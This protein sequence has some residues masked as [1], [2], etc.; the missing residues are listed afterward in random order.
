MRKRIVS[1]ILLAHDG[2][3][4][5]RAAED[6]L[7]GWPIFDRPPLEVLSVA[8]YHSAMPDPIAPGAQEGSLEA[9]RQAL[10]DTRQR[11]EEIA[12]SA[13][14][15]LERL[16]WQ[17]TWD[18]RGGDPTHVI[19]EEA[20]AR[21]IDLVVMGTHGRTGLNRMVLG[22]VAH[23]VLTHAHCSVLVVRGKVPGHALPSTERRTTVAV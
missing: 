21:G 10:G 8:R 15:R 6:V 2:S 4:Q 9:Y 22:S 20:E 12:H 19:V 13:S 1:R 11:Y 23:K 7:A 5:A 3:P 17:T 16:G 14:E 18:V